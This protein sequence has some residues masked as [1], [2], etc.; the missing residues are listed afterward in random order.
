[1]TIEV[2]VKDLL[3]PI[4][5]ENVVGHNLRDDDSP[6]SLYYKIKDARTRARNIER[7]IQQ[8]ESDLDVTKEWQCV[9]ETAIEILSQHSKDV[10]VAVWL[11]ESLVRRH[12][13]VGLNVGFQLLYQLFDRYWD[14]IFPLPDEDGLDTRLAP[15]IGLNG[16]DADGCLIQPINDIPITEGSTV[17]P[18]SLWEYQQSLEIA[19]IKDPKA[20]A[21]KIEQHAVM[22]ESIKKAVEESSAQFYQHLT[23]DVAACITSF[24]ELNLLLEKWCGKNAPPSSTIK[25]TLETYQ[26][27][28]RFITKDAPFV[29][30]SNADTQNT[31]ENLSE[32]IQNENCETI[33]SNN[34]ESRE[35]ALVML[36]KIADFFKRTEPHS[37]IPY[38]L[39]RAVR[40]GNLPFPELLLE[41]IND[42][43]A[44][45]SVYAM[46]GII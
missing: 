13:F 31:T 3:I 5:K 18:F 15:L 12:A 29:V 37:P 43:G 21:K 35:S 25:R 16:D 40:W 45:K 39:D 17:K 24:N 10:E 34:I 41:M 36:V 1:M 23:H 30:L 14:V 20:L 19:K 11:L 4:S 22:P 28:I 6:Q 38:L 32:K 9:Y 2:N 46:A 8:G 7:K 27:H 44:R 33:A 26:D 42:E